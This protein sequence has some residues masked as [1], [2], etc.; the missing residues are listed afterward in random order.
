MTVKKEIS[1][2]KV[3]VVN[4]TSLANNA[5]KFK[6]LDFDVCFVSESSATKLVKQQYEKAYKKE[7]LHFVWGC[8]VPSLTLCRDASESKRG[9]SLGVCM[10]GR[11][12]V[13]LRPSR[14][15]LPE[16]WDRTCRIMVSYMQLPA[17]TVRLVCLYGVQP[18]A[19]D[20][21]VKNNSLWQAVLQIV[22]SCDMPTLIAGD[23]NMKPQKLQMWHCFEEMGYKEVFEQHELRGAPLPPTCNSK[24]CHDTIVFS[25]HFI[26]SFQG[27]KVNQ[28]KLFPNHDPMIACF[29]IQKSMFLYR[30]LPMPTPLHSEVLDSDVFQHCQKKAFDFQM[31]HPVSTMAP[32]LSHEI[33]TKNLEAI[34]KAFEDSYRSA[35][36]IHN[37]FLTSHDSTLQDDSHPYL[38][39]LPKDV[40]GRLRPRAPKVFH[41][42]RSP[43]KGRQGVYEP[44]GETYSLKI[45][46]WV[47]QA[48][49]LQ[50]YVIRCK[51]Y[52]DACMPESVKLQHQKEWH[53]ILAAH[54]FKPSFSQWVLYELHSQICFLQEPPQH[55]VE[56]IYE[57]LQERIKDLVQKEQKQR[58]KIFQFE[59]DLSCCH[60]GG[61]LSHALLR[62]R[63][64]SIIHCFEVVHKQRG[65]RI[66][67][68]KKCAPQIQVENA[69]QLQLHNPIYLDER[70]CEIAITSII[71]DECIE[72][73]QL[74]S[75]VGPKFTLMQKQFVSDPELIQKAFFEFWAPFWL[76]D[77]LFHAE[78][79]DAWKDFLEMTK[80]CP[81][82]CDTDLSLDHTVDEWIDAISTTKTQTSRG[83]CGFS[84]PELRAMHPQGIRYIIDCCKSV[85]HCGLPDW[86]MI[87]KVLLLPKFQ[88]AVQIKDMRPITVFSLIN[89]TWCKVVARRMLRQWSSSIPSCVVGA[90]PKRSCSQLSLQNA[91]LIENEL[92]IGA[93]DVG[94]FYLD[95]CKCFNGFGRLPV[96]LFMQHCGFPRRFALFWK[97][98]LDR[99]SRSLFALD[100]FSTPVGASTGLPE[101]DPLSVCGMAVIGY[102][103]AKLLECLHLIVSVYVDDWSWIGSCARQ[104]IL[105]IRMTQDYL[106]SLKLHADPSKIWVWGSSREARKQWE[107]ISLEI[108]GTPNAFRVASAEKELGIYLHY[109]RQKTIGCQ[110]DRINSALE[111]IKKLKHLPI[112]IQ[113]KAG[114]L[115]TNVWPVALHGCDATYIGQ[116]HFTKLRSFAVETLITKTKFTN[117]LLPLCVLHQGLMDPLVYVISYTLCLWRRL[118][119]TDDSNG[120]LFVHILK[121]AQADPNRAYGPA[122]ALCSYLQIIGWSFNQSGDVVDHLG[123]AFNLKKVSRSTILHLTKDAWN[124]VVSK[125]LDQRSDF[126]D[127][128]VP[129]CQ[130]TYDDRNFPDSRSAAIIAIHQSLGQ[131]FGSKCENWV[132]G[133]ENVDHHCPLCGCEDTRAHFLLECPVLQTKRDDNHRLLQRMKNDFPHQLFLPLVYKSPQPDVVNIMNRTRSL[134]EILPMDIDGTSI[135]DNRVFYTDGSCTFPNIPFGRLAGFA[136]IVDV[137]ENDEARCKEAE[138]SNGVNLFP[139]TLKPLSAGLQ[140]GEQTINR[141]ELTAV[142]QIVRS[143]IPQ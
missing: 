49:R 106:K 14:D 68:S 131:Q 42:R 119:I 26:S 88:G 97:K 55:W 11:S 15:K 48:R 71:A 62:N 139:A 28:E 129:L 23:F 128:P 27:A 73:D 91:I 104:H 22:S 107:A 93:G 99:M 115:Q 9:S 112:S 85:E 7:G 56:E 43:K 50:A 141:A 35:I 20:A 81:K 19:V 87:A 30:D 29:Q 82:L 70:K 36:E 51:K 103:W 47:K 95:I 127:W 5:S 89:R 54:G 130:Y 101:G 132:G 59:I 65:S 37:D 61:A 116:K 40:C 12:S 113:Q 75:N 133:D 96:V 122:T 31:I 80:F 32:N 57:L 10:L 84:Q 74:P 3:A 79:P 67:S 64:Q 90:L 72:I 135:V 134:P 137:A 4:P 83:I 105:A 13:T 41:P 118:L 100:T 8:D 98:S 18:S 69:K 39:S 76:R 21:F 2:L 86:M 114:L 34:G 16:H 109:T 92:K 77:D 123:V 126:Q 52:H 108:A 1:L 58:R 45:S 78:S 66:R 46:S 38:T 143:T 110:L 25:K 124:Q 136:I 33:V 117:C 63:K 44:P 120:D 142:I 60:F 24:T 102:G 121:N 53:A 111:R 6:S 17:F 125:S 94:G 138:K 140:F